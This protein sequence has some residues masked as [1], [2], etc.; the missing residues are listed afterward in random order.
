MEISQLRWD[1]GSRWGHD[2][3]TSGQG[4]K[5]LGA[6]VTPHAGNLSKT[7]IFLFNILFILLNT[8]VSLLLRG[9]II[10]DQTI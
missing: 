6:H 7:K 4:G 2:I 8:N 1:T 3:G 5:H 9:S 10:E